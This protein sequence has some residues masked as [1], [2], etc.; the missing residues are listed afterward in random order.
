MNSPKPSVMMIISQFRPVASGAELQAERLACK[1]AGLG[2]PMRVLTQ[3][4]DPTSLPYEVYQGVEVFRSDFPLAYRLDREAVPTLRYLIKKAHTYDILHNHQMFGHAVVSTLIARWLRKKNVIKL[5]CAGTFGDLEV[6]SQ[7]PYAKWGLQVLRMA[8]AVIAVSR[9]IEAEL[10][11]HDFASE[12]I[13]FIPNGVDLQEFQRTRPFPSTLKRRF[14][15]LGRRTPQKGIDTALRAVKILADKG[16]AGGFEL[17]LYGW[18]YSEWDYRRLARD[19]EVDRYVNFLP[20]DNNIL[21]V[22]QEAH[23]LLLPSVGEG[24]SNV[25]LEAMAMEMPVIASQVSGT[26]EVLQHQKDGLL[27]P[28]RSAEALA[29][30]MELVLSTPEVAFELGRQ[31]RLKVQEYY[32]LDAVAQRYAELYGALMN[33]KVS[34]HQEAQ[35][36]WR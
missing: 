31:A 4:R 27:I 15:L 8:D 18:D 21:E 16:L 1:L 20:F 22:Y 24:L 7:F 5:A 6:F 12:Q 3:H 35:T 34:L 30:A 36:S 29:S 13:H 11:H 26:V 2:F 23:C 25:L 33:K 28:P 10:L 17:N 14:I 19:L 32:S 9:E